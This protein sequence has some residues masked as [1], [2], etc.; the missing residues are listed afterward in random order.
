MIFKNRPIGILYTLLTQHLVR[1]LNYLT[2]F[3]L[4][5]VEIEDTEDVKGTTEEMGQLSLDENQEVHRL[6]HSVIL[7]FHEL[8]N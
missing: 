3:F 2:F 8:D 1:H 5:N 7:L 4:L 6:I